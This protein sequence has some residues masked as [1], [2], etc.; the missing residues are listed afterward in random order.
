MFKDFQIRLSRLIKTL[1]I[2]SFYK[3][4]QI[5]NNA[6]I[7]FRTKLYISKGN[8]VLGEDV[9]LRSISKGYQGSM[10][11]PTTILIDVHNATVKIG[12]NCRLNGVYIHAQKETAEQNVLMVK[13]S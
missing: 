1:T 10:P 3:N 6:K 11:F 5:G 4:I 12:A 9:Y 8:L 2:M 13:Q 7:D